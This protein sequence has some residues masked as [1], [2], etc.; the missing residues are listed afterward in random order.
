M[1][2]ISQV[3]QIHS[4]EG[5]LPRF[6]VFLLCF[7]FNKS[8]RGI[9]FGFLTPATQQANVF[10]IHRESSTVSPRFHFWVVMVILDPCS[11]LYIKL[12]II[13]SPTVEI[14]LWII[15]SP[16]YIYLFP[17]VLK[18]QPRYRVIRTR[19]ILVLF[20]MFRAFLLPQITLYDQHSLSLFKL[21]FYLDFY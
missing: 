19:I 13:F 1:A 16:L 21:S 3:I 2:R 12:W 17:Y 18:W 6:P 7:G 11:I 4:S 20:F 5:G 14:K 15:F 9:Q 10:M 8:W